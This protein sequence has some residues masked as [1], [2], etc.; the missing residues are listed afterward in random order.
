[1]SGR[2]GTLSMTHPVSGATRGVNKVDRVSEKAISPRLQPRPCCSGSRNRPKVLPYS[3]DTPNKA[4]TP[5]PAS[6]RQLAGVS[7]AVT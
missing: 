1:M 6:V 5:L 7:G 3:A 4:N 2:N